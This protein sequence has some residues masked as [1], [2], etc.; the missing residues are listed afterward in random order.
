[1]LVNNGN[2]NFINSFLRPQVKINSCKIIL[3]NKK[4]P[5][6]N[7]END[8][9][10]KTPEKFQ[11]NS[12]NRIPDVIMPNNHSN[13]YTKT[14]IIENNN[15]IN[16]KYSSQINSNYKSKMNSIYR[17]N[18]FAT[19]NNNI[20]NNNFFDNNKVINGGMTQDNFYHEKNSYLLKNNDN[21][22]FINENKSNLFL[23]NS[24]DIF[25]PKSQKVLCKSMSKNLKKN[26]IPYSKPKF[27][28]LKN[29]NIFN[30]NTLKGVRSISK[31]SKK[32]L[33]TYGSFNSL[34]IDKSKNI[35]NEQQLKKSNQ[36]YENSNNNFYLKT[37]NNKRKNFFFEKKN[38]DF[39]NIPNQSNKSFS[40]VISNYRPINN[41]IDTHSHSHFNIPVPISLQ[42]KVINSFDF[43][44]KHS[45]AKETHNKKNTNNYYNNLNN[46]KKNTVENIFRFND[47]QKSIKPIIETKNEE[48][49]LEEESIIYNDSILHGE[50]INNSTISIKTIQ[51][52]N[53]FK[54][55]NSLSYAGKG[56]NFEKQKTN[57]DLPLIHINI[58]DITGFN[59]FGVL[60]GHG[61]NG[62]HVSK[63][64]GD[65]IAN[66]ISNI[67]EIAKIK[68]L[69]KIYEEF[70]KNNYS[71]LSNIFLNADKCL[72]KNKK[73]DANLSG[74]TC[75]IIL[76]IGFHLLS[77][78][79]GD[80]RAIMIYGNNISNTKIFELSHDFKPDSPREKERIYKMGGI[81]D[82]MRDSYGIK[83]GPMR[84]WAKNQFSPGLAMSRSIGDFK[85]KECGI[86]C[87]PE[88]I[89][90]FIN[91]K[92]KYM[93]I[94]SD[95][96]WEFL[97]NKD[98]M[99]MGNFYYFKNDIIGFTNKLI[100]TATNC[101]E[102]E[103]IVI[104]DITAVVVF[105]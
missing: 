80:S 48:E 39:D 24:N 72:Y 70:K 28:T 102:R 6:F 92:S 52:K 33:K 27:D 58:N 5:N 78:N 38:S 36:N 37:P 101:W 95:G 67:K 2:N 54:K 59:I 18:N 50:S 77:A 42:K 26:N 30:S 88:I 64:L 53:Y 51:E 7:N 31:N 60:D 79:V 19:N 74:T 61:V 81:V 40:K 55:Y 8:N 21:E 45:F 29:E 89:E 11:I 86:I 47:K 34:N 103:D 105:F 84:V 94:C 82:Q 1:M 97:S 17:S 4:R 44:K 99:S 15:K 56:L 66:E 98:V 10:L 104:D 43:N 93:V 90:Y 83:R 41:D 49:N 57:Q 87:E 75:V 63:F 16:Y 71:L 85:G 62:H 22:H 46:L 25:S 14:P 69:E 20:Q 68:D 12:I 9:N 100:E 73:I 76:Q 35:F 3:P 96:V 91:D 23:E 13:F 65:F 32:Q